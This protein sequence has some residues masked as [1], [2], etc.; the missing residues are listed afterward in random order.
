MHNHDLVYNDAFT[1]LVPCIVVQS[2][3]F[4][5][6]NTHL[7]SSG[8]NMEEFLSFFIIPL[9]TTFRILHLSYS[10]TDSIWA[11]NLRHYKIRLAQ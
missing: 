6:N 1:N 8:V 2:A 10:Y 11:L 5:E 4:G 9:N 3:G 7:Q